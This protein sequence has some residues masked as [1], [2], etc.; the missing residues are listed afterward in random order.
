MKYLRA[1]TVSCSLI[2]L[3]LFVEFNYRQT[4]SRKK[5]H[6]F[7]STSFKDE[8]EIREPIG[9]KENA[10]L[11]QFHKNEAGTYFHCDP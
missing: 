10:A 5:Q 8:N 11:I 6:Y 7:I 9:K 2:E 4:W 3:C 1:I